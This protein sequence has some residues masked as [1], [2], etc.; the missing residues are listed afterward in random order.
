MT[1]T[2]NEA[3]VV[4][5]F[6]DRLKAEN[7]VDALEQVGFPANSIG[8]VIRGSDALSGGTITDAEGAKDV[9][10]ATAGA[11]TGGMVGGVVAAAATLLIPGLGPFIAG[12]V[13]A[14]F[15][16]GAIA[17]TA[18]GGIIGAMKGL[19]VSEHE[20]KFYESQFHEGRA[21]VAIKAGARW[22]DA[23]EILA[24]FGGMHIHSEAHSPIP[25]AG[26]FHTP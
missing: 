17:G 8:Y 18:I 14:S 22:T 15:F 13:L 4:A 12:G 1:E 9:K 6:E 19:G 24:K 25:T 2:D 3:A 16:G 26:V 21:I 11:I 20:A 10:G 23:V 5:V 7:A